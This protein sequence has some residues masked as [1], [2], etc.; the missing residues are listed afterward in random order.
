MTGE[1]LPLV[2]ALLGGALLGAFYLW[3][4]WVTTR[5][6]TT[7]RR[8]ALLLVASLLG[9]MAVLLGGFWLIADG[10]WERLLAALAGFVVARVLTLRRLH[11][12]APAGAPR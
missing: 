8:P 11:R 12:H 10:R 2:A 4:L 7:A 9:R 3:A 1:L 6:M 5:R